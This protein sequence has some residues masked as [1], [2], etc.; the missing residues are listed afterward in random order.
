MTNLLWKTPSDYQYLFLDMNAYFASCEQQAHPELR[1]KPVAVTPVLCPSGCVI[2]SSYEARAYGVK[3][4]IMI[5]DA[6]RLCPNIICVQSDTFRYLD[7]H[8]KLIKVIK[9]LTPFYT[10]KS[11]DELVIRLSTKD[12]NQDDAIKFAK[13]I[14]SDIKTHLGSYLRCSVGIAPNSYLSK[15]AAE[16]KKPDG[17]TVL[18]MKELPDFF[19]R[20][21]LRDLCGINYRME[22]R[23]HALGIKSP[24]DFFRET[25]ENLK[26]KMGVA[27]DYWHLNLH[28]YDALVDRKIIIPK[29]IS[30]SHVLE[31]RFRNW[32][33]SWPVC[34]KLTYKAASRLRREKLIAKKLML[35]I[36]FYGELRYKKWI[37][38]P[39]C[40]DSM[41]IAKYIR[42]LWD[43]APRYENIPLK[44][45]L[46][47]F[48]LHPAHSYQASLFDT[49]EKGK[50]LFSS[51]DKINNDYSRD[52]VQPANFLY[53]QDSA[54][55]RISFGSPR[56]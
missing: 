24:S 20:L 8:E 25:S 53:V 2:T 7:Y 13:L 46:V 39:S 47:L 37:K 30:Q 38:I 6:K 5:K 26:R 45:A 18:T 35:Y 42:S 52:T 40:S 10:V 17:L 11:V 4:G 21:E 16:F 12:Q 29:T 36:R 27:G 48:D 49:R 32:R 23:L 41:S 28:G 3:T 44:I 15:T 9:N 14:K 43:M 50:K 56:I 51:I 34:Q 31:P 22:M 19:S 1:G 33:L 55:E 54:P